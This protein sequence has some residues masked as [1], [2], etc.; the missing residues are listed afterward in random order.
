V[1]DRSQPLPTGRHLEHRPELA[2]YTSYITSAPGE[3]EEHAHRLLASPSRERL[4]IVLRY[5]LDETEFLSRHGVRSVSRVHATSPYIFRHGGEE[6]RVQY[7]P[8]EST[9][10][11][12]GGNSNWR[13]PVWFPVNYLLGRGAGALRSLYGDTL[14]VE[15]PV[16]SGTML[17]LGAVATELSSRLS[18]IFVPDELYHEYFHGDTG[19][20]VGASHQTGWTALVVR[21]L[22]TVAK[23]R[24]HS[25]R[26]NGSSSA[27]VASL[28]EAR[29]TAE[30]G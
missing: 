7:D 8:A 16:G 13:G 14:R 3:D 19:R 21:C 22:E 4:T 27:R 6:F 18:S 5:L 9:S 17:T 24:G 11:L 15:C 29:I 30:T 28:F 2:K 20:G 1:F 25:A 26:V 12:F 10:G 23:A